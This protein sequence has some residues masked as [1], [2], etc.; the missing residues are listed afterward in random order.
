MGLRKARVEPPAKEIIAEAPASDYALAPGERIAAIDFARGVAVSL[1]ILSHG[2]KGL[3]RFDQ[4]PAWGIVPIHLLTKFSSTLFILVFGIALAVTQLRYVGTL[5]W[6][7]KRTKLLLRGLVVLFWYK[8]LT[9]VE[10]SLQYSRQEVLDTLLYKSFPVYVEILGFY[11]LALLWIPFVLGFWAKTPLAL[12]LASPVLL[13][14]FSLVLAKNWDFFGSESLRAL[15]VESEKHYTWGQLSRGPLVLIGLLLGEALLRLRGRGV[16]MWKPALGFAL[17]SVGLFAFF[18]AR[19]TYTSTSLDEELLAIAKNVGKHPPELNFMLFSGG[20]AFLVMAAALAGGR[21]LASVLRP[22]SLVGKDA[23]QS[24]ICHIFVL[25]IFYRY[26]L[27][28]WQKIDYAMA[29]QL[30]FLLIGITAC[31]VK[32]VHWIKEKS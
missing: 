25:F 31:W 22:I 32:A 14:G 21:R 17:V 18:F 30:S 24:F 20:G 5:A 12:K 3:L 7:K 15:L 27:D 6:P 1:M 19:T 16:R 28:Y 2:V 9:V 26:L 29:L 11:G 10:L 13:F 4:F 8:A 23:L